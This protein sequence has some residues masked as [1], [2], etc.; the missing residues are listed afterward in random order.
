M[1][2]KVITEIKQNVV[3]LAICM[4]AH[5]WILPGYHKFFNFLITINVNTI[6]I[7]SNVELLLTGVPG[8][9]PVWTWHRRAYIHRETGIWTTRFCR[10]LWRLGQ[11]TLECK[12]TFYIDLILWKIIQYA[13][14]SCNKHG[15][16]Q[17]HID[18]L[19]VADVLFIAMYSVCISGWKILWAAEERIGWEK[20]Q[21]GT[22]TI[23]KCPTRNTTWYMCF[24]K[25]LSRWI[26]NASF[27][28]SMYKKVKLL[29]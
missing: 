18:W 11:R 2:C 21:P 28:R 27:Y 3:Y 8:D 1:H 6:I 5:E 26:A 29:Y 22:S 15:R 24:I 19:A 10:L 17:T 16:F 13:T 12:Q 23:C 20:C 4:H 14:V 25:G 7:V 9:W